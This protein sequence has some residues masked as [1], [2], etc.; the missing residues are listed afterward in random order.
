[1]AVYFLVVQAEEVDGHI[2][3]FFLFAPY[4]VP[5]RGVVGPR[6]RATTSD[7]DLCCGPGPSRK[8]A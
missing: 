3:T 8:R 1:M 4:S 2:E 5:V 7:A 6:M